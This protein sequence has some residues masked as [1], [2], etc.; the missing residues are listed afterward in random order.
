MTLRGDGLI[1]LLHALRE[2]GL[3][4][5]YAKWHISLFIYLLCAIRD[6]NL[7]IKCNEGDWLIHLLYAKRNNG[8]FI[9]HGQ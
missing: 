6:D 4:I 9:T 8:L 5:Y 3:F 7:F 2:D 1:C